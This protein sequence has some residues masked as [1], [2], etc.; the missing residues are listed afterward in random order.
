MKTN[1]VNRR[2]PR[3]P[4]VY[5]VQSRV[6]HV[7]VLED[8]QLMSAAAPQDVATLA[9]NGRQ[10]QVRSGEWILG[11]DPAAKA[12][13]GKSADAQLAKLDRLLAGKG[14]DGHIT[15]RLG[16][17]GQYLVELPST[18]PYDKLLNAARKLPGF[19]YLE[20]NRMLTGGSIPNDEKFEQTWGLH[21]T[22][23]AYYGFSKPDA[24]IDA[25]EAWDITTGS[26]DVV[27]GVIDTGVDYTHPDLAANMWHNPGEVPGDGID[28]DNNGYV[29]D[30]Y[31]IDACNHD[32][33][34]MDD[35]GHGTHCSGTI[36]A[37]GDNGIGVAGVNWHVKIM[38]LKFLSAEGSGDTADAIE[39][40]NYAVMMRQRGVNI[41]LTSN[42]W[43]GD[44]E[45]QAMKD[46]ID[47]SGR[48][49]MMFV[50]AAGNDGADNDGDWKHYPAAYDCANIV[51]VAAT[52]CFD[53]MPYWSNYGLTSVD[54]GAPG[55]GILS[56]VPNGEYDTYSGT[57]MATPHVAGAAALAW[58][59]KPTATWQEVKAALLAGTDPL[60]SLQG[61]VLTGGRL[62]VFNTLRI[63]AGGVPNSVSGVAYDDANHN[64][65][66]DDGEA[67]LPGVTVYFDDNDN[68]SLDTSTA[69]V[70]SV[71]VPV[72]IPEVGKVES[73]IK[74]GGI[75][76]RI[77]DVDVSLDID[78]TYESD[79]KVFL[80]AP[81]GA[82]VEL[83]TAVGDSSDG[84]KGLV[85]DD[86]SERGIGDA[87]PPMTGRY[88]PEG[89]LSDLDG[90]DPNG[91]W[92]LEIEDTEINDA[93]TL[94]SW[95]L[96]IQT[97][98]RS[99]A[100]DA[101]G[102]YSFGGVAPGEYVVRQVVPAGKTQVAPAAGSYDVLMEAGKVVAQ[103]DFGDYNGTPPAEARVV[104][105][106]VFYNH[107]AFDG[108]DSAASANDDGAI[109]TDKRALLPGQTATF[110]NYTGFTRGVNGIM[111]DVKALP[112][113]A[114][115]RADD[116]LF[117]VGH[118]LDGRPA[119]WPA[120]PAPAEITV[121]RGA[122]TDGSDRITLT[123]PD[124]A[125]HNGWLQV[126]VKPTARTGIGAADVFYF[127][128]LVGDTGNGAAAAV[129][130]MDLALVRSRVGSN[131]LRPE[132]VFDVNHDDRINVL[133]LAAVRGNQ[134]ARLDLNVAA[135]DIRPESLSRQRGAPVT[136]GVLGGQ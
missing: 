63:I 94:N 15:R 90:L 82:R 112:A 46:A 3:Q 111:I 48:A 103:R 129:T 38:A 87:P 55:D 79:L 24:D 78:H 73:G 109:A 39:C 95:S 124:G 43:G 41:P 118:A 122:G 69:T 57:S 106:S 121:R 133:D 75:V 98:E 62:N 29:D 68:G 92:K 74:A 47:A 54:L 132:D 84:F 44:E 100:T 11:V 17:T 64:G 105:R 128:N 27:V 127:G 14:G 61:K 81:N 107:S 18:L 50:V 134:G 110:A 25:P 125:I 22:G 23:Q 89:K 120:A 9:W 65:T 12:V 37:V 16:R 113:G 85:L 114:E 58:S 70:E 28:N 45:E 123:F 52:D 83:F 108:Y 80:V 56:T 88:R 32:S 36:G 26:G 86:E 131:R 72:P 1:R 66:R 40:L 8:R 10:E 7:E 67:G 126:T 6:S 53:E 33:D 2:A 5:T 59:L 30:V 20:P 136:R 96:T 42:S 76:G 77:L 104:G 21:N 99:V 119:D 51:T 130:A 116:F 71:D 13:A 19:R 93:G 97:G 91:T 35:Q 34:P 115:L 31:G 60:N 49:G 102:A 117:R 101:Q 135:V 4:G